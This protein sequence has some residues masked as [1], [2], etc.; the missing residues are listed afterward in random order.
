VLLLSGCQGGRSETVE[1]LIGMLRVGQ[2]GDAAECQ[3]ALLDESEVSDE[4]V[5]HVA[6]GVASNNA[7]DDDFELAE[8]SEDLSGEDQDA[9]R[10]IVDEFADCAD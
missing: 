4:G 3:A 9:F 10:E 6:L 8:I 2:S 1:S 5:L 7:M